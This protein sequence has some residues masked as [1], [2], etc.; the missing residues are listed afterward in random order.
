MFIL[1]SGVVVNLVLVWVLVS[2]T[3]LDV[4]S[5][6]M[7]CG[8]DQQKYHDHN[9]EHNQGNQKGKEKL[10]VHPVYRLSLHLRK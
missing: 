5:P 7:D 2:F 9:Q 10:T 4:D 6:Q 3:V 8:F 1:L